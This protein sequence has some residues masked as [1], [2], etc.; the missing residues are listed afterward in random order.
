MLAVAFVCVPGG[1]YDNSHVRRLIQQVDNHLTLP[2]YFHVIT[3]SD[4]PGWWAKIDLF[5][6]GLF[7]DRV[8]YLDLDVT[9]VG[10][11]D[12][13]VN[14]PLG[15][16][17]AMRDGLNRWMINSSVMVWNA[18]EQDHIYKQFR[19]EVMDQ[20]HGD[21]D[22]IN[23]VGISSK[24]PSRWIHSWKYDLDRGKKDPDPDARVIVYHGKTK[25]WDIENNDS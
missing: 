7:D 14:Y 22:W 23:K 13:L 9:V 19:P 12:D 1:V 6:P 5:K 11:L 3:S 2:H 24:F 4:K 17:T 18:G 10:S 16:F 21:Q 15:S 20:F 25:P 8:L